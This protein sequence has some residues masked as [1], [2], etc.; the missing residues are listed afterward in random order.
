MPEEILEFI[1]SKRVG[2]VAVQM[3]DGTPHAATVHFAHIDEPPTFIVLTSPTYRK[4]EPLK[5]NGK[6]LASFVV[7]TEEE[8]GQKTLQMDG[9]AVLADTPEIR[10]AYF[11]KFPDKDGKHPDD[12]FFTFAPAW[13]RFSKWE[14]SGK[15]VITSDGNTVVTPKH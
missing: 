6:A 5:Q 12:I 14:P 3:L 4:L 1:R 13:W 15:T 8:V 7:G 2:V 9:E 11:V 10:E